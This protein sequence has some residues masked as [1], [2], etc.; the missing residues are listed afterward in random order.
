MAYG[1]ARYKVTQVSRVLPD[2]ECFWGWN[3]IVLLRTIFFIDPRLA[4]RAVEAFFVVAD[5]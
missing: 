1:R 5:L 4:M 3:V 2:P